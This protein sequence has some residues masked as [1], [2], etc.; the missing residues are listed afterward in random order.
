MKWFLVAAL[1]LPTITFGMLQHTGYRHVLSDSLYMK[2]IFKQRS[3][4]TVYTPKVLLMNLVTEA[5]KSKHF[6]HFYLH[7]IRSQVREADFRNEWSII[8]AEPFYNMLMFI[9][10]DGNNDK[11]RP[12]RIKLHEKDFNV[13]ALGYSSKSIPSID[14]IEF[15]GNIDV[16]NEPKHYQA[17]ATK[18]AML[19]EE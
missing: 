6:R 14:V 13:I 19:M 5:S 11:P 9:P 15:M 12:Q 3:Q 10:W 7:G 17:I 2:K 18:C 1:L 8:N 4:A 16:L